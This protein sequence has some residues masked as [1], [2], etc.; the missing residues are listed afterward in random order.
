MVDLILEEGTNHTRDVMITAAH[1]H[2]GYV[3][4]DLIETIL[5]YPVSKELAFLQQNELMKKLTLQVPVSG[6]E[7]NPDVVTSILLEL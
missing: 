2:P 6:L 5:G 4:Q 7:Y 1:L 3:T